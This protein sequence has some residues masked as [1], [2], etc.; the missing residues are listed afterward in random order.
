MNTAHTTEPPPASPTTGARSRLGNVVR[1][2]AEPVIGEDSRDPRESGDLRDT[3]PVPSTPQ[4][5]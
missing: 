2:H 1:W 5:L 3:R 4:P